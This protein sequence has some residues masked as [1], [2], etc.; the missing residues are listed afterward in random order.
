MEQWSELYNI[1]GTRV[2]KIMF[3]VIL[4]APVVAEID[5]KIAGKLG[6]SMVLW[7]CR[8][9][10]AVVTTIFKIFKSSN[11][12]SVRNLTDEKR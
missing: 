7:G 1:D 6:V 2:D 4:C 11:I 8:L 9:G 12:K 10:A 5:S 3:D